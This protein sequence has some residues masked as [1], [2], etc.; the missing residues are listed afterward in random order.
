MEVI[1]SEFHSALSNTP[2]KRQRVD[3]TWIRHGHSQRHENYCK[4]TQLGQVHGNARLGMVDAGP[5]PVECFWY[6]GLW[7]SPAWAGWSKVVWEKVGYRSHAL[8]R[9]ELPLHAPQSN[10]FLS[11]LPAKKWLHKSSQFFLPELSYI[12]VPGT[13]TWSCWMTAAMP[14]CTPTWRRPSS[15]RS[16]ASRASPGMTSTTTPMPVTH[17]TVPKGPLVGSALTNSLAQWKCRPRRANVIA[18]VVRFYLKSLWQWKHSG[19]GLWV[20]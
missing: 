6:V 18:S 1:C 5:L 20:V 10:G 8:R 3:I 12:F 11:F 4:L 17:D 19:C 13:R 15:W 2:P 7:V 9:S 14:T 16:W